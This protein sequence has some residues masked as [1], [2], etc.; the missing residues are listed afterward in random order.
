MRGAQR[1]AC[2]AAHPCPP[3]RY[4][5]R[6]IA[7]TTSRSASSNLSTSTATRRRKGEPRSSMGRSLMPVKGEMC[8]QAKCPRWGPSGAGSAPS[9]APTNAA[10]ASQPEITR[11]HARVELFGR[12]S[13]TRGAA[14]L[15][16]RGRAMVAADRRGALDPV[17]P[18]DAIV[19]TAALVA[20]ASSRGGR[21]RRAACLDLRA[22]CCA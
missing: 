7:V 22:A 13:T 5:V 18:S 21:R 11:F 19:A 6:N 1:G 17:L 12:E 9:G 4:I 2:G 10:R 16:P 20:Q 3:A 14:G 8:A 15:A